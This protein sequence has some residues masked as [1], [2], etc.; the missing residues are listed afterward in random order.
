M[1]SEPY[2]CTCV[3]IHYYYS[4]GNRHPIAINSGFLWN[5]VWMTAINFFLWAV[6]CNMFKSL[7]DLLMASRDLLLRLE[8][9][10]F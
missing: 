7:N 5:P 1:L 2:T 10:L 9:S 6:D 3:L 4:T 8:C